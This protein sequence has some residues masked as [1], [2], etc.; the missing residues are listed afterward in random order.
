MLDFLRLKLFYHVKLFPKKLN[1][2]VKGWTIAD[3]K[4]SMQNVLE[5][6]K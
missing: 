4:I 1:P 6:G 3:P 5:L 2:F